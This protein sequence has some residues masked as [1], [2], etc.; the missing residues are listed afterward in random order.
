[1]KTDGPLSEQDVPEL[2]QALGAEHF[3]GQLQLEQ[4]GER[5]AITVREGRFVFASTSNP[6]Y[7]LGPR[8]LRRGLITVKQM[9]EA[10]RSKPSAKRYG[11][12]LVEMGALE[13]KELVRGVV[14]QTRDVILRAFQWTEGQYRLEQGKASEEAITLSM[15][16]PQ[17]IFDGISQIEAWSRVEHGCGGLGQRYAPAE[18]AET[19]FKELTLDFDQVALFRA[20]KE[21]RDVES[22]CTESVLSNF[23]VCRNLWAYR[24]IGLVRRVEGDVS[25][26]KPA[27]ADQ[28][29]PFDDDGLHFVLADDE[30]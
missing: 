23:E 25:A 26:G 12:V 9:E 7:R 19:L 15:S 17:I 30:S 28:E 8:L 2:V 20:V 14:E 11:T 6:D 22:L 24:V 5:I 13:P 27:P 10:G 1:V 3:S 18:G 4:P 16:T 29:K 21:I